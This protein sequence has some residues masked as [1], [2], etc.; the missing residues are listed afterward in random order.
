MLFIIIITVIIVIIL[1][2]LLIL[3]LLWSL[4]LLVRVDLSG[5]LV[6]SCTGVHTAQHFDFSNLNSKD[7]TT[8]DNQGGN[9]KILFYAR[10]NSYL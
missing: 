7:D 6:N 2:L 9:T 3:L 5:T 8:S 4:C 10:T 1:L